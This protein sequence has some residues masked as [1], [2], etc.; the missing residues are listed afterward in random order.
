MCT[1]ICWKCSCCQKVDIRVL[2]KYCCNPD[3]RQKYIH[4]KKMLCF[5]CSHNYCQFV[6]KRF[7][8]SCCQKSWINF[9]TVSMTE[10]EL[11]SFL[12]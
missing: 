2:D 6:E 11:E 12:R 4:N 9:E 3:C 1:V 10:K 8:V 5:H 7:G